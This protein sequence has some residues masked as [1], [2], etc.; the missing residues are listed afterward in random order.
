MATQNGTDTQDNFFSADAGGCGIGIGGKNPISLPV[1]SFPTDGIYDPSNA[2]S[3]LAKQLGANPTAPASYDAILKLSDSLANVTLT[4][5]QIAQGYEDSLNLN[6]HIS[7]VT[8]AGQFS[9]TGP[10]GLR[11][12]TVKGGCSNINISGVVHQH[13]SSETVKVD[14]WSDQTYNSSTGIVINLTA[15]DG[16]AIKVIARYGCGLTLQ[17]ACKRDVIGSLELTAYWWVKWLARKITRV[18]V[19]KSGP[20]WLP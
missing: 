6:S 5:V 3:I 17:G 9:T 12:I 1:N 16:K 11:V 8:V 13:G 4:N 14:D 20:S 15:T 7:N 19:G 18:P 10:Q 2:T